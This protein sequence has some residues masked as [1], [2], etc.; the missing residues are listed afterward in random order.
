MARKIKIKPTP[1]HLL[2]TSNRKESFFRALRCIARRF[3]REKYVVLEPSTHDVSKKIRDFIEKV[4]ESETDFNEANKRIMAM[5]NEILCN[6]EFKIKDV[7]YLVIPNGAIKQGGEA[8]PIDPHG[9]EA[10]HIRKILRL[11]V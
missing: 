10:K 2:E 9:E 4:S 1:I 3:D 8:T 7:E 5:L 11:H 6:D